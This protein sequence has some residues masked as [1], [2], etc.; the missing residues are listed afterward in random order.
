MHG[1][2][3]LKASAPPDPERVKA[4]EKKVCS[5]VDG[6]CPDCAGTRHPL[7]AAACLL[8]THMIR[9]CMQAALFGQLAGEVLARSAAKR[10][11]PESL[12]L[13]A[14]LLELHPEMYTGWNYRRTA[15]VPVS[16]WQHGS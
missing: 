11:D 14:K 1:R 9:R 7:V 16:S 15:L 5:T 4:A 8:L 3:R 2:P 6:L 10:Y 12:A 13:S